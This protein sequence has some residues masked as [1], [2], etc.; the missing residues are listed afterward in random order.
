MH[1]WNVKI[2]QNIDIQ[3]WSKSTNKIFMESK[4]EMHRIFAVIA[5]ADFSVPP[6]CCG[7]ERTFIA[8]NKFWNIS[9]R[10]KPRTY[11]YENACIPNEVSFQIYM[12]H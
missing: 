5:T 11:M 8:K 10:S 12:T 3:M 7:D 6:T 1:S 9:F 4:F 2:D